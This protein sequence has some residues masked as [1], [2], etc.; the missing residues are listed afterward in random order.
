[1]TS[2]VCDRYN[3]DFQLYRK[4]KPC[5]NAYAVSFSGQRV[6]LYKVYKHSTFD[7]YNYMPKVSRPIL[8]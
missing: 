4:N 5:S 1:M 7:T 2:S 8:H 6:G 3:H